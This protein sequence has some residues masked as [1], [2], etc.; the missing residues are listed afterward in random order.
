MIEE[1]IGN[2]LVLICTGTIFLDKTPIAQAL[3]KL[4]NDFSWNWNI[5]VSQNIPSFGQNSQNGKGFF[6]TNSTYD[7]DIISKYKIPKI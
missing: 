2:G 6:F 7:G 4:I 1:N 3:K 5:S